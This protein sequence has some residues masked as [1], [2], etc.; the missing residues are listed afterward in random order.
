M[1]QDQ[2]QYLLSYAV[3]EAQ[4][5]LRHIMMGDFCLI[6]HEVKVFNLYI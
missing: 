1:N 6:V 4:Q 2:R 5:Q 3:A